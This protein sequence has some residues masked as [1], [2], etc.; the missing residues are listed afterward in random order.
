MVISAGWTSGVELR[1]YSNG[2]TIYA[3]EWS[4]EEVDRLQDNRCC[5]RVDVPVH[6]FSEGISTVVAAACAA[7]RCDEHVVL[8]EDDTLLLSTQ[9]PSRFELVLTKPQTDL[10][11][12]EDSNAGFCGSV[13]GPL[14]R[15]TMCETIS[16]FPFEPKTADCSRTPKTEGSGGYDEVSSSLP[17]GAFGMRCQVLMCVVVLLLGGRHADP[18]CVLALLR[19]TPRSAYLRAR[20]AIHHANVA[21]FG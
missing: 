4:W 7:R 18:V 12:S 13:S 20:H 9:N 10:H 6:L 14:S 21:S 17:Y 15:T 19:Q 1:I 11:Y 3:R 16:H 8:T 5:F 2:D